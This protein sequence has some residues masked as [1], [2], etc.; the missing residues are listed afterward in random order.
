MTPAVDGPSL[1]AVT[2]LLDSWYPPGWA[3]SFDA[4]GTVCGDP[5]VPVRRVLLAVDPV[6]AVAEEA[7][8]WGADLLVVHH[9]LLLRAVHGVAATTPK[10]RVVHDLV[11]GG[12]GLHVCHTNADSP[13]SGVSESLALALGLTDQ[14]PIAPEPVEAMDKLVVFVPPESLDAV[15]DAVTGAGAGAVGGYDRCTFVSTG[16]GSFRPLSGA[17]PAVGAVGRLERSPE[18]RLE[19]VLPRDRRPAVLEA[20]RAA[21]PYEQP[22]FDLLE[23]AAVPSARGHGRIGRLARPLTLGDFARQVVSALPSTASAL[24]MAG[25]PLRRV[26]WVAV[27]GGAGDFLLEQVRGAGVDVYVTS[28]LRHHPVSEFVEHAGADPATPAVI[29]VP[30]M[31]AEWT[32]LPRLADRLTTALTGDRSAAATTV[33]VR[34]STVLTDPWTG[35][36]AMSGPGA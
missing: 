8:E 9:P 17:A 19:T 20:L 28:D 16:I 14:R 15:S 33:E 30:H 31:A 29:D 25:D 26:E 34:V 10:G 11:R 12:V 5:S 18:A 22:A 35:H 2:G 13:P 27:C 7:L 36:L 24:R 23:L 1:G 32:W 21:H 3:D 6:R 4:V